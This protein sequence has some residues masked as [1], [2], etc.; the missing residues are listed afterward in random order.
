M[1]IDNI[2]AVENAVASPMS[3]GCVEGTNS[4]VKTIKKTM[5][6]RYGVRLLRAKLL[7]RSIV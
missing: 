4:K 1:E 6:G 7:Y 3:N 5:Y 2:D